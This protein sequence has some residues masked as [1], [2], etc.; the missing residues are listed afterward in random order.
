MEIIVC[1]VLLGR[2]TLTDDSRGFAIG[3]FYF[4]GGWSDDLGHAIV[5]CREYGKF[6]HK[7]SPRDKRPLKAW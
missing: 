2:F 6:R 3:A 5:E 1:R 7:W 4:L